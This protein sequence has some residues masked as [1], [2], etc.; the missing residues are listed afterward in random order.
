MYASHV[1]FLLSASCVSGRGQARPRRCTCVADAIV[2]SPADRTLHAQTHGVG[3][4]LQPR[5][6]FIQKLGRFISR[7]YFSKGTEAVSMETSL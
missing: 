1:C 4:V 6:I 7:R 2:T 5:R 3:T